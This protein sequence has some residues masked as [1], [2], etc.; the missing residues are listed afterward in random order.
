[1]SILNGGYH[2]WVKEI[3]EIESSENDDSNNQ[4]PKKKFTVK[5][6]SQMVRN[7]DQMLANFSSNPPKVQVAD[8]RPPNLFNGKFQSLILIE[9]KLFLRAE[10]GHMPGALSI[11]HGSV[12]DPTNQ[13]LKS[14][15]QLTESKHIYTV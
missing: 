13:C 1:M 3:N 6:N 9:Y 11:P 7:F 4:K 10:A 5:M 8:A 15:E 12:L 2:R 14:K